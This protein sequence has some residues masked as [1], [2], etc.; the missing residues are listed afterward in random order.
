MAE[1]GPVASGS[2][3]NPKLCIFCPGLVDGVALASHLAHDENGYRM[4]K[5]AEQTNVYAPFYK[6]YITGATEKIR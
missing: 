2:H 6:A 3:S 5:S 1:S 4:G